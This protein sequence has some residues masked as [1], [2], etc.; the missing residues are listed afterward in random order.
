MIFGRLDERET[1][2]SRPAP[3][4]LTDIPQ[5]RPVEQHA[6]R[7]SEAIAAG[8]RVPRPIAPDPTHD[9]E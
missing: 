9:P 5:P 6:V 3:Q 7:H 4:I 2:N 1:Q 8:E